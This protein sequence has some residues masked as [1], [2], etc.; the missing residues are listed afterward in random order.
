MPAN[1][2][3]DYF[4]EEKKLRQARS[5]DEKIEIIEKM[6]AI[7]PHHKGTDKL[8]AA[9]RA[10]IA[11]LKEER[12]RRP[13]SQRKGDTLWNVK[14]EGAGQVLF[15][16]FPNSGKSALV[17][18]L[19]GEALEVADYPYTTRHLQVRMMRFEDIMIQLVDTTAIGD[20]NT[21]MWFGNIIRK[22][23]VIVP[24]IALADALDTEYELVMDEIK[25]YLPGLEAEQAKIVIV[26]NKIDLTEY[27]K[28][29]DE[30]EKRAGRQY[31]VVPV[32]AMNDVKLHYLK[33]VIFKAL[34]VIRLYSKLPGKKPDLKVPFILDRGS[35]V[36][37]AAER[38]HKDFLAKLRY[39]KLWRE[40]SL[41]GMM[42]SK[43]FVLE[44]RDVIELHL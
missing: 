21:H 27:S 20:E 8:I 13:H 19:T 43:D 22:A 35:T 39:A 29:L 6:L 5:I 4:E 28:Y 16:G 14:K 11:K 15:I 18:S 36:I 31:K 42:V 25:R 41:N 24:V 40:G 38:I 30:F 2:P 10:K 33:D 9:H 7:M 3:P 34:G 44:D 32:S 37:A 17:S 26:V 12:E 23:D 1:L